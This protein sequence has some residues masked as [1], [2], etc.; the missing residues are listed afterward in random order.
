MLKDHIDFGFADHVDEQLLEF[1]EEGKLV[2][3][4]DGKSIG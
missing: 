1:D 2:K 3:I 4:T